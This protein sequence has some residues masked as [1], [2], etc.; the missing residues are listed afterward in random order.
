MTTHLVTGGA[1]FVGVSLVR[2]LLKRGDR[3]VIMDDLSRV[4]SEQRLADLKKEAGEA[5]VPAIHDICDR[6]AVEQT[7]VE[8]GPFAS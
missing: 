3:V 4:G 1:G 6:E 2:E 7:F 5:L 8:Q